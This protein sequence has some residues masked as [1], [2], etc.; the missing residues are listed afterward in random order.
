M[1]RHRNLLG[2]NLPDQCCTPGPTGQRGPQGPPG[3]RGQVG[4]TGATG[5]AGAT[6]ATGAT[7]PIGPLVISSM[8]ISGVLEPNETGIFSLKRLSEA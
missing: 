1:S 4:A 8:A 5:A 2:R 3:V 6:G 7:G